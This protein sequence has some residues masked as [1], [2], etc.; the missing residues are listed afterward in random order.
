M[1]F[2]AEYLAEGEFDAGLDVGAKAVVS[3]A[4][5][6]DAGR[7]VGDGEISLLG[8]ADLAGGV[9]FGVAN[10]D[11]GAGDGGVMGVLYGA[12]DGCGAGLCWEQGQQ[13]GGRSYH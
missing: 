11:S 2:D 5:F 10:N 12:A 1:D 9:S 4:K 3:N 7:E 8:G 6:V 13:Q